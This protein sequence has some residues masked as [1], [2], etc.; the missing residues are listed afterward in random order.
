MSHLPSNFQSSRLGG[1]QRFELPLHLERVEHDHGEVTPFLAAEAIG[2]R[3][4][5]EGYPE[6][7]AL[8]ARNCC[9][10]TS[11]VGAHFLTQV[12]QSQPEKCSSATVLTILS[13]VSSF[14]ECFCALRV[15]S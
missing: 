4:R 15:S 3:W 12:L 8:Q 2:I 7:G 1:P 5:I 9:K 6:D 13:P 14:G 11:A 10:S